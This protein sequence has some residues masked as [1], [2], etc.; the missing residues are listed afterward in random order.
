MLEDADWLDA[1]LR[2]GGPRMRSS[3]VTQ[4]DEWLDG[5]VTVGAGWMEWLG[6]IVGHSCAGRNGGSVVDEWLDGRLAAGAGW[7]GER[8]H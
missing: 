7:M 3:R 5:R 4:V 8:R 2:A 6:G 1:T